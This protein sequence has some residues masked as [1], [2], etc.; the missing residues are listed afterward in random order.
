VDFTFN[1]EQVALRDVAR[2]ACE[3]EVDGAALRAMADDP[4]GFTDELWRHLV[5][6]GWTG[7]LVAEEHGGAGAGLLETCIVLEQMGRIPMP[8]PFFSSSVLA[9]LAA[10]ALEADDLLPGLAD[11]SRR[12]TVALAEMGH[13]D[14]LSTIRTRVRRR[15]SDWVASGHKPL[16]VDGHTA[17]W[18]IV[19]ARGEDGV[20]S[21][22]LD[23]SGEEASASSDGAVSLEAVP[24]LDPT[25]K[26]ARL[27]LD[28]ARVVPLGPVGGQA[29]L[30]RRVL[31]DVAVALA[32]ELTGVADRA[33]EEATEYAK[34]RV[35]FDRPVATYQVVKHRLVDMF[36][37]LEMSRV[38]AQ[39]AAWASD[40]DDPAREK[41]AAMAASYA[42]E[43]AVR[44]TG[45][46]I[47]THG[48]VGFTWAN[49][50]HFLYK[51][52]KQNEILLGGAGF[53]R[54][55]LAKMLVEAG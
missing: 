18:I 40:A 28:E 29:G 37:A 9:A 33:L 25:R 53:E 38:G 26:G 22:L 55:R 10:R 45:D 11:G 23:R 2:Q 49:D 41:A 13:G 27:V 34:Q 47:Q 6:L 17:A 14:P 8:G 7:M 1:E 15:G 31:D 3:R 4:I 16:V 24:T 5:E 42:A 50:A 30:W 54:Q 21:F 39:Y 20:R 36:H 48:G 32:S 35:V 19:V 44:A 12:G 51:R 46:N 43:A 52:A